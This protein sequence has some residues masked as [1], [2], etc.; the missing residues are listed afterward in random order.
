MA[1][2]DAETKASNDRLRPGNDFIETIRGY[3]TIE[4]TRTGQRASAD[5]GDIDNIVQKL[6]ERDPDRYR[7]IPL[8]RRGGREIGLHCRIPSG[9][10]IPVMD[11][12]QRLRRFVHD[13]LGDQRLPP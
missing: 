9:W 7:Q 11:L 2:A 10:R 3:R 13:A 1:R 4:D 12:L 6:N 8:S 5:L